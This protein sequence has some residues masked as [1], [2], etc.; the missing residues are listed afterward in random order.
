MAETSSVAE[1]LK[2]EGNTLFQAGKYAEAIDK[3]GDAIELD[4]TAPA[5]YCNRAFCH[6]KMENHGL[7]IADATLS[8]ELEKTFVKAYYRRGSAFMALGKYKDALKDFKSVRQLK[9]NDKEAFEKFKACEKEVKR[10]A[11]E[12]AIH[13]DDPASVSV[14]ES[15][16]ISSMSV[17]DSY[18][19]PRLQWPLTHELALEVA[20]GVQHAA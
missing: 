1:R 17:E 6:L 3:Y 11:F 12:R 5:Y 7:A 8:L 9:P 4:P 13:T 16:D 20:Q 10:Q 15:L 2:G 19:G 18:D 14:L